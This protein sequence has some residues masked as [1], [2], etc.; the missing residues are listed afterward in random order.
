MSSGM[1]GGHLG[2]STQSGLG[3]TGIPK[4]LQKDRWSMKHD[5]HDSMKDRV[6]PFGRTSIL[7]LAQYI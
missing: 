5:N 7:I 3:S 4:L 2:M 1:P 6:F